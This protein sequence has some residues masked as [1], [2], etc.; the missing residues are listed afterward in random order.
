MRSLTQRSLLGWIALLL[1]ALSLVTGASLNSSAMLKIMQQRYGEDGVAIMGAWNRLMSESVNR[2]TNEKLNAVNQFFN[3]NIHYVEDLQ[4]WKK[5]DY[6]ATPLE[7]LGMRAGDCEDYA[8]AK[9]LTLIALGIP[10]DQLRLIYVK[11]RIGGPQSHIFQAH[12]VLGYYPTPEAIPEI[13]D[14]LVSAITTANRRP[15]LQPVFSFNSEGLWIG[16]QHTTADPTARLSRWRDLLN[17]AQAEGFSLNPVQQSPTGHTSSSSS[18]TSSA[19]NSQHND[20]MA[21]TDTSSASSDGQTQ[22]IAIGSSVSLAGTGATSSTSAVQNPSALSDTHSSL[23]NEK[24][25]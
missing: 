19:V 18:V 15:D 24:G 2:S 13:L 14:S 10:L 21:S 25:N 17:R 12:M 3:R 11:A 9:Y 22:P 7:T 16:N 20:P 5:N 23:N 8:I 6:W 4:L 1:L